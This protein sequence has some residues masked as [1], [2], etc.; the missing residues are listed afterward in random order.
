MA[1]VWIVGDVEIITGEDGSVTLVEYGALFD[2]HLYDP[3]DTD[4]VDLVAV[5]TGRVLL[6]V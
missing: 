2:V 6:P 1:T 5:V 4:V 3:S